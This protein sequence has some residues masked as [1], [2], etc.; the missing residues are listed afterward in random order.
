[1]KRHHYFRSAVIITG[2]AAGIGS[3]LSLLL[4]DRGARLALADCNAVKLEAV[5]SQC[6][7][8]G[9]KAI[10]VPTDVTRQSQCK[11]LID[12]TIAAFSRI[13]VL[14]N[15]AGITMSARCDEVPDPVLFEQVTQVNYFG[16]VYCTYHALPF[17]KKTQG[18][19][20]GI[21]SLAGKFGIP[22][23]SGYSASKHA[24]AGFFDTLRMELADFGVSVTMIYP[25]FVA[26]GMGPQAYE[27]SGKPL[28]RISIFF[29]KVLP[30]ETCARSI[31]QAA[32]RRKREVVIPARVRLGLWLK[33]IA[34]GILDHFVLKAVGAGYAAHRPTGR[35]WKRMANAGKGLP[36]DTKTTDRDPDPKI[37]C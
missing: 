19:I 11:N 27:E 36:P 32:A 9:A 13:D 24:M 22:T 23:R 31:L 16:S 4:A 6:R 10:G 17:L 28:G 8:R 21:S 3:E 20:V 12:Q 5:V 29:N 18:R 7:R 2:A 34:P 35:R 15:N 1:M 30:V 33:L 14:F 37:I 25:G 26:T